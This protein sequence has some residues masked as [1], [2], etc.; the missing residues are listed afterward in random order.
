[1]IDVRGKIAAALE[2]RRSYQDRIDKLSDAW[3][4][5]ARC[6][7]TL[8]DVTTRAGGEIAGLERRA[9]EGVTAESVRSSDWNLAELNE[10][11]REIEELTPDIAAVRA[12]FHRST[13]NIGVVGQAAAGKSTLL[14]TITG[15]DEVVIP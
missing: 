15:L 9:A 11:R 6:V 4:A 8:A 13:V 3:D 5:L 1:M 14:R 10:L 7:D 12:R 2:S